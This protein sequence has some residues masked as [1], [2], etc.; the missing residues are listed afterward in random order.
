MDEIVQYAAEQDVHHEK[1]KMK[2]QLQVRQQ[3]GRVTQKELQN[4]KKQSESQS[5]LLSNYPMEIANTLAAPNLHCLENFATSSGNMI[6][7]PPS[8][9]NIYATAA[10]V[11]ESNSRFNSNNQ[12]SGGQPRDIS[13]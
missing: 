1:K 8:I 10:A 3:I 12:Q 6:E 9:S 13:N 4:L 11:N 7:M 5:T 2:S